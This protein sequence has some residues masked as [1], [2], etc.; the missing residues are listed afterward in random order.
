M[1]LEVF[2]E[3]LE[4]SGLNRRQ[5]AEKSGIPYTTVVGWTK[6]GRLPD[7]NALIK[8]ADFFKCSTDLLTDRQT[9]ND[10]YY[11]MGVL[12]SENVLIKNYRKLSSDKKELVLKLTEK[13]LDAD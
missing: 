4:E 9:E 3:L 7:Y 8:I 10:N 13:L 1:F 11:S 2:N 5:F 6:L 12:P